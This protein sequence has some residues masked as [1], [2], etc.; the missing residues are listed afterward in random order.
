MDGDFLDGL[1]EGIKTLLDIGDLGCITPVVLCW[2][3]DDVMQLP[4]PIALETVGED[5][6]NLELM[7]LAGFS[8]GNVVM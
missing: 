8:V 7:R 2:E 3:V 1:Y 5:T 4:F 6:A